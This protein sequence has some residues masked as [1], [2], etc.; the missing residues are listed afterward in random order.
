M[1]PSIVVP[2]NVIVFIFGLIEYGQA[3]NWFE[4]AI[5]GDWQLGFF[6]GAVVVVVIFGLI[7]KY[8]KAIDELVSGLRELGRQ[9][10]DRL[11]K[12]EHQ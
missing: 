6:E 11:K 1:N 5:G 2:R 10:K 3:R 9:R 7:R 8:G 12:Q 4:S